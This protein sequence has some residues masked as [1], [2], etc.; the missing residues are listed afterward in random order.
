[1]H[2]HIQAQRIQVVIFQAC[3]GYI[4]CWGMLMYSHYNID[5]YACIPIRILQTTC[6][7]NVHWRR[8]EGE[9][10]DIYIQFR[11]YLSVCRE[12][13]PGTPHGS[14]HPPS[15]TRSPLAQVY[16]RE[17]WYVSRKI[18]ERKVPTH[19]LTPPPPTNWN[20]GGDQHPCLSP[21]HYYDGHRKIFTL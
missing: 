21:L 6:T 1:M 9:R 10:Y 14:A 4:K 19:T 20:G 2:V 13:V 16:M 18:P 11:L 8:H 7:Y 12:P 3:W 5:A 17:G 15:R